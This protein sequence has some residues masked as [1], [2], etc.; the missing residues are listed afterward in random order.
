MNITTSRKFSQG[1]TSFENIARLQ[2]Q[3]LSSKDDDISITFSNTNRQ[4]YGKPFIFLLGCL[5]ALGKQYNKTVHL[6]LPPRLKRHFKNMNILDYDHCVSSGTHTFFQI[7]DDSDIIKLIQDNMQDVPIEMSDELTEEMISLIG[8]IYNNSI[9][10]SNSDYIIGG[11]YHK[12][13]T[14]CHRD[15]FSLSC[16]D[17]GVVMIYNVWEY[18]QEREFKDKQFDSN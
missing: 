1:Q 11:C 4:R 18:L 5:S 2:N 3:I 17:T 8:E 16:Y 9:D 6:M 10:H 13:S 12:S 14:K 15:R 7:D